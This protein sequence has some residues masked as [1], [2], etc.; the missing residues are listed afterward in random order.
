MSTVIT[1]ERRCELG[2]GGGGSAAMRATSLDA[3]WSVL[4]LSW[5][6]CWC[7][8]RNWSSWRLPLAAGRRLPAICPAVRRCAP[9]HVLLDYRLVI[10]SCNSIDPSCKRIN[11]AWRT[12]HLYQSAT[13]EQSA[14]VPACPRN[15]FFLNCN[16]SCLPVVKSRLIDLLKWLETM[17]SSSASS[18]TVA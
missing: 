6:P 17:H 8:C 13:W 4:T 16:S 1:N 2:G 11:L 12:L 9:C 10:T 5:R 15:D 7:W 14:V 3:V 18:W